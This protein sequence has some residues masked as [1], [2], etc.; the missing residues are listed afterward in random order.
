MVRP[1][2]HTAEDDEAALPSGEVT[3]LFTDVEGST[4]LWEEH[5]E[6]MAQALEAHD[7]C[8]RTA[9]ADHGGYVFTTAGDSFSVAFADPVSAISAAVDAQLALREPV[10]GLVIRV[11]MGLHSGAAIVRDGDYFGPVLNRT[12][13][14]MAVGHGGQILVSGALHD[15]IA[16]RLREGLELNDLGEHQ[17]K[18]LSRPEHVY[19]LLHPELDARFPPLRSIRTTATNLPVQL[20][21]FVGREVEMAEA[22]ELVRTNRLVTLTGTGGS[23][24]TRMAIQL[25]A[26]LIDAFPGGVRL[27]ELAP[28]RDPDLVVDEVATVLGVTL[29]PEHDPVA[30]IAEKVGDRKL[31][32]ILDNSEHLVSRVAELSEHLLRSCPG[33]KILATSIELLRVTGEVAYRM[34]SLAL[35]RDDDDLETLRHRDAVRLFTERAAQVRPDFAVADD[36]RDPVVAIARRLDG[37]P[38]ALELAA[39]RLRTLSVQQIADRLDERFRL[40]GGGRTTVERHK[41]LEAAIAWSHDLL[42]EPEKVLFRRLSVFAGNFA[43]EAIEHVCAGSPLDP[44][45]VIDLITEL[46]DKSMVATEDGPNREIRYRLLDTLRRYGGLRLQEAGEDSTLRHSHVEYYAK[47]AAEIE[48]RH[49][50]DGSGVA[51]AILDQDQD[52]MR[53]ALS[54]ALGHGRTELAATIVSRLWFLWYHSGRS[55]EGLE[56]TNALFNADP[57]L[58]DELLA[59]SLHAHGTLMGIWHEPKAGIEVLEREVA[60]RERMQDPILLSSALNNLGNLFR[61]TGET[62]KAIHVLNR[63]IEAKR[64]SGR[65]VS[66]ELGGL[67]EVYL[68]LEDYDTAMDL[69]ADALEEAAKS[70]DSYGLALA[71]FDLGQAAVRR[72]DAARARPLLEEAR[73]SFLAQGVRPGVAEADFFLALVSR[74]AG[75]RKATANRLLAS[76]DAADAH[77]TAALRL[78]VM[79]VAATVIADRELAAEVLGSV[80]AE[81]RRSTETQP[82]YFLRDFAEA[83]QQLTLALGDAR[84]R[85]RFAAGERRVLSEAVAQLRYALREEI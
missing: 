30:T 60:L 64:Q 76:L 26:E 45:Q 67:A 31:L 12:A 52:N 20:T 23:G 40:L 54:F 9:A 39:A 73:E 77:W 66:T 83:E 82:A 3:F 53:S 58:D 50:T 15:S 18:D 56:W 70:G 75:D 47:L 24:K 32:L 19:Q 51:A 57:E 7:R 79:Q 65:S 34:P 36:N 63:A 13:R 33:L 59:S 6:Q 25:G 22:A 71:T 43:L 37:I 49:I 81:R 8:L 11:R 74:A 14:L 68:N 61:D 78:W 27:V 72:G 28:L 41:T 44:F 5:G 38:L 1:G 80:H 55:R 16:G 42:T 35:P 10:A 17:L 21:S 62:D 84:F 48:Q 85:N 29:Q 4:A 2:S 69:Y 46:A